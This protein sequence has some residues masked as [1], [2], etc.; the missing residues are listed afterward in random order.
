M[1]A[2]MV[3]IFMT[4]PGSAQ[5]ATDAWVIGSGTD[6]AKRSEKERAALLAL[7]AGDAPVVLDA[8]ALDLVAA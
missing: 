1:A 3:R 8:G 6:P 7:L 2:D 4:D 5:P